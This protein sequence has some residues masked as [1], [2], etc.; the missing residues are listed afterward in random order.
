LCARALPLACPPPC[1]HTL[2]QPPAAFSRAQFRRSIEGLQDEWQGWT[3]DLLSRNCNHF[4]EALVEILGVGPLPGARP[5]VRAHTVTHARAHARMAERPPARFR[6]LFLPLPCAAAWVNRFAVNADYALET[7]QTALTE[8]KK[9]WKSSADTLTLAT[10]W[11]KD[12]LTIG[13]PRPAL[14]WRRSA[15]FQHNTLPPH[16]TC[17]RTAAALRRATDP[18]LLAVPPPF[19]PQQQQPPGAQAAAAAP[20][21]AAPAAA[22][23]APAAAPAA[24]APAAAA[25]ATA[26][27]AA[28]A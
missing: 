6:L 11:L 26:A 22:A 28:A 20:A 3:Y 25:A 21:A 18:A 17:S 10:G 9:I 7:S 14:H 19:G 15:A 1:A 13:A 2:T 4:C 23:A 24:S 16:F 8:V 5:L 12:H 27:S